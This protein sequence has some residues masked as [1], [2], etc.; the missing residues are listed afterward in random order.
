MFLD[1]IKKQKRC[2]IFRRQYNGRKPGRILSLMEQT[3]SNL[4]DM[5]IGVAQK[6]FL[7]TRFPERGVFLYR[8][9]YEMLRPVYQKTI[10]P[11]DVLILWGGGNFGSEYPEQEKVRRQIIAD[12]PSNRIVSFPQ[13]IYFEKTPEGQK[14][15]ALSQTVYGA[16]PDLYLVAREQASFQNM[17][18]AFPR[19]HV[20]LVPDIVLCLRDQKPAVKR[21]GVL[22]CLRSDREGVFSPAQ[23]KKLAE[24]CRRWGEVSVTDM[25][26]PAYMTMEQREREVERKLAEFRRSEAVVTDRLHGMIFAALTGTPCVV[27]PNYNGKIQATYRWIKSLPYLRLVQTTEEVAPALEEL[28]PCPLQKYDPSFLDSYYNALAGLF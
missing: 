21:S 8:S 4:G 18:E 27:L 7:E 28:L 9:W 25:Y 23:R 19:N 10:E 22:I 16:H 24:Q 12:F 26:G 20:L 5:A 3:Y 1:F 6:W 13:T 17:K 14:E 11:E 2:M 15:L